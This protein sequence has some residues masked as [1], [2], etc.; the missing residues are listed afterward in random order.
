MTHVDFEVR[1]AVRD[2]FLSR[3]SEVCIVGAAG[4]GKSNGA[5][6][7][8]HLLCL[9]Y[10][11][12]RCL[13][14]RKTHASLASTTL[15]TFNKKVAKEMLANRSVRWYGGSANKPPAYLY[16][17]G[18]E[19]VVGGMNDPGKVMSAEYDIVFADESTELTVEDWE[20]ARSRLRN[21]VLPW[22]AQWAACN[23]GPPTHW[24][25]QRSN[26]GQLRMLTSLHR[27]NP[28]YYT[29][30]GR[31]TT[32]GAAYMSILDGLTGVRRAR[33]LHGQWAAADGLVYEEWN[34]AIHL[35]DKFDV[36]EDW[37]R[38]MSVDFGFTNPM[39]VQWWA[40]DPDGRAYLYRE[41]Y[42]TQTLVEDMAKLALSF[43]QDRHG[44]WTE[45]KPKALICDHD[46]EGRATLARYLKMSTRAADKRVKIGIQQVQARMRVAG[47]GKPRLMIM[48]DCTVKRDRTLVDAKKPAATAEEI[49]G[50]VWLNNDK[51][52][53]TVEKTG[54]HG[55]DAMR[56]LCMH[57]DPPGRQRKPIQSPTTLSPAG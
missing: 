22:Q 10:P 47:D 14:V 11:G 16:S 46:A 5:L 55:A 43:M 53:D 31:L 35:V 27:D 44:K 56:Y 37:P 34:D 38:Y 2:L 21:G 24:L 15:V 30:D 25:K 32:A 54:D 50:Y 19:I 9:Q 4:T 49:P 1:G 8:L 51:K 12:I 42:K 57:L 52:E 18:S 17:N 3:D 33:L 36:P 48:R 39:V 23:P 45:P 20:L 26:D 28:A 6:M 29:R 40:V 7:R 41:L 13:I